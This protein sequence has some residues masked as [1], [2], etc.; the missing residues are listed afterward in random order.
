MTAAAARVPMATVPW[1]DDKIERL[2]QS[3]TGTTYYPGQMMARINSNGLADHATDITG[4]TFDG[5]NAESDRV[6]V[7]AAD[8]PGRPIKIE[9]PWRFTMAIAAAVAG[10][11]GKKVYVVDNQTVGYT[12][13]NSV[14]VG[15]VDQVLSA[16]SVLIIP[17]WSPLNPV[18]VSGNV[19]AFAGST[20]VDQ[21][22]F[23]DNLADALSFA[24]GSNIFLTFTTTDGSEVTKILT[25]N[26]TGV[27]NAGGAIQ[28]TAGS[29]GTT[30]G[31]GGTI[32]ETAGAGGA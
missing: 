30:S 26:A 6:V 19:L 31:T 32:T 21:I 7:N 9:R 16:T 13:S 27:T 29:G 20:G 12:S 5:I 8:T 24:Q 17:L 10:D 18:A 11:E 15:F 2:S 22:T 4:I 25:P 14:L 1:G 23:P 28:I 3:G